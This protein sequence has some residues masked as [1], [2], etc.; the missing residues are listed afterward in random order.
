MSVRRRSYRDPDTG[1]VEDVWM[2]DVN[3]VHPS[4][5]E[6]RVRKV[7]PV[8]TR[9]GAEEYERQLRAAMLDGSFM[10]EEV[11]T[12]TLGEGEAAEDGLSFVR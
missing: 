2:V 8:N 5:R 3:F 4:G 10:R 11:R 9:R 1:A 7:S 12:P 6:Q